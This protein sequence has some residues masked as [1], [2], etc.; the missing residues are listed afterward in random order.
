MIRDDLDE[1]KLSSVPAISVPCAS[2]A[3][4][5]GC[6]TDDGLL[7]EERK[8]REKVRNCFEVRLSVL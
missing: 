7:D 3:A 5:T 2:C 4:V 8:E 1:S 6:C